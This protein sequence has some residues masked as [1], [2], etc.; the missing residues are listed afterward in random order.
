MKWLGWLERGARLMRPT[1]VFPKLGVFTPSSDG[2]RYEGGRQVG[3]EKEKKKTLCDESIV[4][5]E[6]LV[7]I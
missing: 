7:R 3:F 5:E 4:D 2:Y 1:G 6:G